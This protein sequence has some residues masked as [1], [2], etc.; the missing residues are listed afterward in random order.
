MDIKEKFH[1]FNDSERSI[2]A[3]SLARDGD[4][5]PM[6]ER[7]IALMM[8]RLFDKQC[9][10][11]NPFRVDTERELTDILVVTDRTMLFIQAKDSPNTGD[12]LRRSMDRKRKT[13]QSHIQ[14]P[15]NQLRGALTYARDND[16]ITIKISDEIITIPIT[17]K[18]MVGLIIVREMFDDDYPACSVPVLE[19]VR[20][21]ELP[22]ALLDY[23]QLHLLTQNLKTPARFVNG[24]YRIL[25]VALK[26]EQFPKSVWS[27]LPSDKSD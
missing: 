8:K 7:D 18:Q 26:N 11:I 3:T 19:V 14:K 12:I 25:D 22:I 2:A 4:P 24:L 16:G 1:G 27:G 6:Q 10:Y 9:L 20:A 13:I 21:L 23:Q 5:G 15:S 17:G